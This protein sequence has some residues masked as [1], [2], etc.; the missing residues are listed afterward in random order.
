MSAKV[1]C[2]VGAQRV[3]TLPIDE[4]R[5][6]R[7]ALRASPPEA[8][9]WN[10]WRGRGVRLRPTAPIG[11]NRSLTQ[12]WRKERMGMIA[13]VGATSLMFRQGIGR[14]VRREGLPRNRR[15]HFLD[16]RIYDPAWRLL[17]QPVVK[18]LAPYRRRIMV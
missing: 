14:L 17:L 3:F 11:T 6:H 4:P 2:G 5:T 16:T 12:A 15:L 7:Q 18:A 13:E 10:R 8:P 1:R 9:V